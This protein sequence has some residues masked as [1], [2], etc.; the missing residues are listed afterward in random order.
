MCANWR[1]R[2]DEVRNL[3]IRQLAFVWMED[4]TTEMIRASVE[5]KIDSFAEGDLEHGTEIILALL[6]IATKEDDIKPPGNAVS[7][8]S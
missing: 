6:D 2:Y 5:K 4:S 3:Y 1:C 8:V 7:A